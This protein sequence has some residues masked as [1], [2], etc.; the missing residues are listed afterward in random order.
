ETVV[1]GVPRDEWAGGEFAADRVDAGGETAV[2]PIPVR[3]EHTEEHAGVELIRAC[4]P[5]EAVSPGRPAVVINEP[6]DRGGFRAP[7]RD[8]A[9][10]KVALLGQ[11]Y[12]SVERDPAH[13][14]RLGEWLWRAAHLPESCVGSAPDPGHERRRLRE[15]PRDLGVEAASGVDVQPG[16]VQHVAV[17]VE[18]ELVDCSVSDAN[19]PRAA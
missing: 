6:R 13:H 15:P 18:L 8:I 19:G 2:V 4:V 14:L 16:H 1:T 11:A 12:R 9:G 3:E 17:D 7:G 5:R 10:R